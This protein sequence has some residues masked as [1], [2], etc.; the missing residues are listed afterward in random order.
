VYALAY[1][2]PH[3]IVPGRM[4]LHLVATASIAVVSVQPGRMLVGKPGTFDHL[5]ASQ[6][7]SEG[8]EFRV[9]SAAAF[10]VDGFT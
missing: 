3:E 5:R 2:Q 4:E 8:L 7:S 6:L 10:P 9:R 1:G